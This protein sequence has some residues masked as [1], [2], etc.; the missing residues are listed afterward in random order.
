[1]HFYGRG[2]F[3][4]ALSAPRLF[5]PGVFSVDISLMAP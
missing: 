5:D 1:M 3:G 2:P 4:F